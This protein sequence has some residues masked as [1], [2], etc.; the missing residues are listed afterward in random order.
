MITAI[1]GGERK[2]LPPRFGYTRCNVWYIDPHG[3]QLLPMLNVGSSK[4]LEQIA[5]VLPVDSFEN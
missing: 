5:A 1:Q 4:Y 3:W 2:A